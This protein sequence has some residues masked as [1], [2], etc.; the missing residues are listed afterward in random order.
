MRAVANWPTKRGSV[1]SSPSRGGASACRNHAHLGSGQLALWDPASGRFL[2]SLLGHTH[3][4]W[5]VSVS[6]DGTTVATAA[7]DETVKLWDA[8]PPRLDRSLPPLTAREYGSMDFA[9]TPDGQTV[10]VARAIGREWF[11]P[12]DGSLGYLVDASFEVNGFDSK[13]GSTRFHHVLGRGMRIHDVSVTP[14]GTFVI[15]NSPNDEH[16]VLDVAAGNRLATIGPCYRVFEAGDRGLI[17][18]RPA[19][20]IEVIDADT[21]ETGSR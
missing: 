15:L 7:S 14:G 10:I 13:T 9:F 3:K 19:E 11:S 6:P 2:G 20:A 18:K 4:I 12:P 5:G 16:T 8:R 1:G 21:G 17:V